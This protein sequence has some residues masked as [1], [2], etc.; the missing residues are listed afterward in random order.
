MDKY[1][2]GQVAE[3]TGVPAKT[4]RFYEEKGIVSKAKR[5][6]N[7]YRYFTDENLE[8]IRVIKNARDLGLSLVEIKRLM[9]GCKDGRCCHTEEENKELIDNHIK[10]LTERI[11]QMEEL[12]RRMVRL[13]KDGPYCCGILHELVIS[14]EKGR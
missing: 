2:V 6:E 4:I 5:S 8:E 7:G 11:R 9:L 13:Q 12:K 1:N 10:M 3:V 14:K